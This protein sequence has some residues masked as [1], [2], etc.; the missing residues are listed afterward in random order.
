MSTDPITNVAGEINIEKLTKEI[1]TKLLGSD[2]S[3]ANESAFKRDREQHRI[4]L[5]R[6]DELQQLI[7]QLQA[8]SSN[9]GTAEK[10]YKEA[11]TRSMSAHHGRQATIAA[12]STLPKIMVRLKKGV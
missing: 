1:A 5:A 11:G 10:A 6:I 4:L 2:S 8:A 3:V 9:I 7:P 12:T